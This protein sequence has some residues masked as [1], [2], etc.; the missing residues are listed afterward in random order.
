MTKDV[1]YASEKWW[2]VLGSFMFGA[3]LFSFMVDAKHGS[4][5]AIGGIALLLA[6]MD[7]GLTLKNDRLEK[8]IKD[9]EYKTKEMK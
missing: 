8:R 4:N 7:L 5:L 3:I 9:L 6:A 2:S 1:L